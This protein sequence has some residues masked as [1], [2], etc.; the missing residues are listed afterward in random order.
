VLSGSKLK[1]SQG[2]P[3][4]PPPDRSDKGAEFDDLAHLAAAER[5]RRVVVIA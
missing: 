5:R 4:V 1:V 2:V 3:A